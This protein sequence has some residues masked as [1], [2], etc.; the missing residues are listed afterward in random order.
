MF[1][2]RDVFPNHMDVFASVCS[3]PGRPYNSSHCAYNVPFLKRA[4]MSMS[5]ALVDVMVLSAT[6]VKVILL[7]TRFLRTSNPSAGFRGFFIPFH[8][9]FGLVIDAIFVVKMLK[10]LLKCPI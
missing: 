6:A 3:T 9:K 1:L 4:L 10:T 7:L 8:F 2:V 5:S